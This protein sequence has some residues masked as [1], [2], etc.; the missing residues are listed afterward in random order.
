M[1]FSLNLSYEL[2]YR[3]APVNFETIDSLPVGS[4]TCFRY[5]FFFDDVFIRTK[6]I[7][8]G[9]RKP[10]SKKE[11][12]II[13]SGFP[14]LPRDDEHLFIPVGRYSMLQTVPAVSEGELSRHILPFSA[15]RQE[16]TVYVR[17]IKENELECVMQL[18]FPE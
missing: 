9:T 7:W 4:E 14:P 13:E 2:T 11:K 18:F 17:F 1:V 8:S 10:L 3:E 16:G 15:S 6:L 5:H 12:D